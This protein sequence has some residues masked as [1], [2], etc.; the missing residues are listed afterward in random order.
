MRRGFTLIE[1][2]IVIA[3]IA[4]VASI[5]IPVLLAAQRVSNER[6]GCVSLKTNSAAQT[7]FR[8]SDADGNRVQLAQDLVS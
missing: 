5:A 1:L 4:V 3:I 2:M 6:N 7:N 8:A